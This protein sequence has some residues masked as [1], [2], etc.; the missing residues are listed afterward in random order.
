MKNSYNNPTRKKI[1]NATLKLFVK[2]GYH[3]TSI[4]DISNAIRLTKGGI[5]SHFK[6][7]DILLKTILEEYEKNFLDIMI[8]EV[9]AVRGTG[10]QKMIHLLKFATNFA[11]ENRELC[12]CLVVLSTELCSPGKKY[13][14][15]V[16]LYVKYRKLFADILKEGV[17]DGSFR[18]DVNPNI[19]ALN[20]IGVNEGNLLQWNMNKGEC[21][22]GKFTRSLMRLL[23]NGIRKYK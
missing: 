11:A 12:L 5:Y 18:E 10:M 17:E 9:R 6:R 22:S 16:R 13:K 23:L 21:N 7:K 3:G 1:I 19:L 4:S 15:I 20:L 14:H 2:N 8:E